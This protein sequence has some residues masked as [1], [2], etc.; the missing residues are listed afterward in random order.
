M[1]IIT[2]VNQIKQYDV[3]EAYGQD[4]QGVTIRWISEKRTGGDEYLHNFA[5]RYF[6]IKAGGYLAP[7]HHPW[8]Q[9]IAVT[10]GEME[11]TGKHGG[12]KLVAGDCAYFP[13]NEEHGF[14]TISKEDAEFFCVIGCIGNGENCIGISD[15]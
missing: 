11:I 14:K 7:H 12:R 8:E 1:A 6:V 5:L 10:K 13:S 2:N 9:E 3:K 4:S 15:E